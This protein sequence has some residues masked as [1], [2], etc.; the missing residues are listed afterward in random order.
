[1]TTA[2]RV[3]GEKP[4]T[5]YQKRM[6]SGEKVTISDSPHVNALA[7][8]RISHRLRVIAHMA[9]LGLSNR[10]IASRTGYT[11][12]RLSVVL[13]T[14][15]VIAEVEKTRREIFSRSDAQALVTMLPRAYETIWETLEDRGEK[16]SV[17]VD[18]AFRVIERLHGKPKQAVEVGGTLLKDVF[19]M[20][21]RQAAAFEKF[22][23]AS[24]RATVVEAGPAEPAQPREADA[25]DGGEAAILRSASSA[26]RSSPDPRAS[27]YFSEGEDAMEIDE[28]DETLVGEDEAMKS[29][30]AEFSGRLGASPV[31]GRKA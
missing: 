3:E 27:A 17:R 8:R 16:Q 26:Q 1:M 20:L 28:G 12:A 10:E 5:T 31:K 4:L 22:A 2:E 11:E 13:R 6:A 21:D 29:F 14:K 15:E 24:E 18:T 7:P 30:L 25:R 19:A 9:A 23:P